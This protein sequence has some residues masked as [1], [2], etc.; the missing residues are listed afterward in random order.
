MAASFHSSLALRLNANTLRFESVPIE[1][2]AWSINDIGTLYGA[3]LVERFRT[4]GG[5][6][7][8]L[9]DRIDRL[10]SS[11][12]L[13]GIQSKSI[14]EQYGTICQQ[15]LDVNRKLVEESGDV[16]VVTLLSPG[17]PKEG[18]SGQSPTCMLH[19]SPIPFEKLARWYKLGTSLRTG[20][21]SVVPGECWPTQIK[22]RSRL[23]YFLSDSKVEVIESESLAVLRTVRGRVADTSVANILVV[24]QD[25]RIMSPCRDDILLGCTLRQTERLLASMG[26]TIEYCDLLELDL[27]DAREVILT[28]SGGIVWR[29]SSFNGNAIN[30]G[31]TGEIALMLT[32]LWKAYAGIDFIEQANKYSGLSQVVGSQS[33]LPQ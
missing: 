5:R 14:A 9:E 27:A 12:R 33:S 23:P 22:T 16:G 17:E 25:G 21:Q 32:D 31:L 29:A 15:L 26:K 24:D 13:L 1:K 2:L 11:A 28:G 4:F 18:A 8:N 7:I 30:N 6:L 19:L 20:S 3:I 10:F